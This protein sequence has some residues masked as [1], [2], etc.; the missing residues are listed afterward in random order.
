MA[1]P[2]NCGQSDMDQLEPLRGYAAWRDDL[3]GDVGLLPGSQFRP[4]S[5]E[6]LFHGSSRP[7]GGRNRADTNAAHVH[8]AHIDHDHSWGGGGSRL[9]GLPAA[10]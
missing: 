6:G 1:R 3:D 7:G 8:V 9:D 2:A 4:H 5:G 10:G